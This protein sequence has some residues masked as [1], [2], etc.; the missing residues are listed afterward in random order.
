MVFKVVGDFS[1]FPSIM[2]ELDVYNY[3]F[4]NNILYISDVNGTKRLKTKLNSLFNNNCFVKPL[5]TSD[6][7]SEPVNAR[8]WC[9]KQDAWARLIDFE[10]KNQKDLQKTIEML[11]RIDQYLSERGM[12]DGGNDDKEEAG[13]TT[14][15]E[16]RD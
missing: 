13:K 12:Q 10:K 3:T 6:I 16:T 14:E 7:A 11:D 4:I 5:A 2:H 1:N 9:E 15:E 8:D